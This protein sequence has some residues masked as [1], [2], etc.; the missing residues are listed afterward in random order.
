MFNKYRFEPGIGMGKYFRDLPIRKVSNEEIIRNSAWNLIIH[1]NILN[2]KLKKLNLIR[3][4]SM[5]IQNQNIFLYF[6][7]FVHLNLH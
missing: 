4:I 7:C 6:F 1:L 3:K 2:L 5:R